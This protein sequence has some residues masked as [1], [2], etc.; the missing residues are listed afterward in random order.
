VPSALL[1]GVRGMF[2]HFECDLIVLWGRSLNRCGLAFVS[3]ILKA[4]HP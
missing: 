4:E 3:V 2:A 1:N